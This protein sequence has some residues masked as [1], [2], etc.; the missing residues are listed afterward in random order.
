MDMWTCLLLRTF[1]LCFERFLHPLPWGR[2]RLHS[3]HPLYGC[4]ILYHKEESVCILCILSTVFASF[5]MRKIGFA[6][7][8]SSLQFLHPLP[9]GRERLHSVHP[10]YSFCILYH[11]E[12]SVCIL[13]ILSTVFAS[14][15][16]RKRAFAFCA[17]SLRLLHP[18]PWGR[19]RLHSVH[20]LYSFCILYHEEESVC[21]LCIL[22]TRDS[23]PHC[24]AQNHLDTSRYVQIHI[25]KVKL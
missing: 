23:V 9:W 14:S 7:C 1:G 12:E 6:F 10:L 5:T 19:E 21:I 15:T 20:P 13:C 2:E 16:M 18:L 22:S 25:A 3:V 17:S 8:A 4:C 11:E 24:T